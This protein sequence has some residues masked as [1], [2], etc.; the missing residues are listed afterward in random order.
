MIYD[1]I[2]HHE[3]TPAARWML[4]LAIY[5]NILRRIKNCQVAISQFPIFFSD[6]ECRGRKFHTAASVSEFPE[7]C[8]AEV[9][10]IT[11]QQM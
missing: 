4:F 1:G 8:A 11:S 2:L 7:R 5:Q 6:F 10:K 3:K 9:R